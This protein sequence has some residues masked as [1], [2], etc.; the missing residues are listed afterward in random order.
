MKLSWV[1]LAI[2]W[3]DQ[4]NVLE[5]NKFEEMSEFLG[6]VILFDIKGFAEMKLQQIYPELQEA[7]G[8]LKY[9]SV[10]QECLADSSFKNH[11]NR[12][13]RTFNKFN[14]VAWFRLSAEK[15]ETLK[16]V[17]LTTITGRWIIQKRPKA[18]FE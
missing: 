15:P 1:W 7:E 6:E 18:N 17:R 11:P 10:L 16:E 5:F 2:D 4:E 14:S 12:P 3:E 8:S 13:P 9:P